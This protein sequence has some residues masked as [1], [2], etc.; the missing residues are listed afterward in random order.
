MDIVMEMTKFD[1]RTRARA[2]EFFRMN[3]SNNNKFLKSLI[4]CGL[5]T[6]RK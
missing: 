5:L 3:E 2:L 6:F 4:H 1:M